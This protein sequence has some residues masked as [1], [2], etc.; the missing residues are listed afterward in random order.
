MHV[1]FYFC[2]V[3]ANQWRHEFSALMASH[4]GWDGRKRRQLFL[5]FLSMPEWVRWLKLEK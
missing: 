1:L 3:W 2:G 5:R 4:R